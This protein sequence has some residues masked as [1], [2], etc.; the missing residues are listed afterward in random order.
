MS[1]QR[2]GL[3][4]SHGE[5]N[6]EL[7]ALT[8]EVSSFVEPL[9]A[10]SCV[11]PI[12]R[13]TLRDHRTLRKFKL[14][15]LLSRNTCRITRLVWSPWRPFT[16]LGR[17]YNWSSEYSI[18]HASQTIQPLCVRGDSFAAKTNI[19]H[20]KHILCAT[21]RHQNEVENLLFLMS[22]LERLQRR[23]CTNQIQLPMKVLSTLVDTDFLE[24]GNFVELC[25]Q[26]NTF[27]LHVLHIE[28][29]TKEWPV[30]TCFQ[31]LN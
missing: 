9:L 14:G 5:L 12:I 2:S 24:S 31:T 29:C 15:H 3:G 22:L 28:I 10:C 4:V 11:T 30:Y 6:R 16:S 21:H 17:H 26:K 18:L 25:L 19:P 27:L 7:G 20:W 23:Y 8:C 13:S 1:S